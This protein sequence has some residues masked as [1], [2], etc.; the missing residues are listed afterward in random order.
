MTAD[1]QLERFIARYS[2]DVA[3]QA[4]DVLSRLRVR[5]PGA[6]QL[7]YDNYN[8][9]AI[10]FGPN[11][12]T[13]QV[14]FSVALYPRWVSLFFLQGATLADPQKLLQGK[15]SKVRHIVIE[16]P[17]HLDRPA[18]RALMNRALKQA[19]TPI[20]KTQRNRVVIKSVSARQRPRRPGAAS[21]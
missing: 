2:R 12:K 8:A 21:A 4:R 5:L 18:L 3:A 15:G 16:K 11:E 13:S 20:D 19:A 17:E 7:V 14:V 9:L 10:G 6:V 1:E